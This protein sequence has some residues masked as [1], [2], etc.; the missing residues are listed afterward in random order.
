MDTKVT[1][2]TKTHKHTCFSC[3]TEACTVARYYEVGALLT[4]RP[5]P[6]EKPRTPPRPPHVVVICDRMHCQQALQSLREHYEV[7][8][9]DCAAWCRMVLWSE[10]HPL[11][12]VALPAWEALERAA[13][14]LLNGRAGFRAT[15]AVVQE[16]LGNDDS[17]PAKAT[18]A[19][20]HAMYTAWIDTPKTIPVNE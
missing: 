10:T 2:L 9:T 20:A 18:R 3:G 4:A 13:A 19:L 7:Q 17:A 14:D 1:Q 8:E 11:Q 15:W 16:Q 12:N 6:P 5:A